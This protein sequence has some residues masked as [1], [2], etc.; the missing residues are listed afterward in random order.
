MFLFFEN[1]EGN[2]YFAAVLFQLF[3][4]KKCQKTAYSSYSAFIFTF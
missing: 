3:L 4:K 2:N 1:V